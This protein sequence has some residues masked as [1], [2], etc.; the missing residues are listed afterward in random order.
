[1]ARK[2]ASQVKWQK[3]AKKSSKPNQNEQEKLKS[4]KL[5]NSP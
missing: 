4:E 1:M 3:R 5:K 2:V